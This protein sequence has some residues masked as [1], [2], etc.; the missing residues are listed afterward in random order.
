MYAYKDFYMTIHGRFICKSPK[1]E[2]TQ[3]LIRKNGSTNCWIV[4]QWILL[5]NEKELLLIHTLVNHRIMLS[6]KSWKKWSIYSIIP[7]T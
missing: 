7:F 1:L 5:S 6:E 4:R 3:T 2:T